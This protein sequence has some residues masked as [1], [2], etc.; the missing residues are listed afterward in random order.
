[1]TFVPCFLW[2]LLGAPYVESLRSNERL[3]GALKAITASVVGV[4]LNL[5]AWLAINVL[6]AAVHESEGPLGTRLLVRDWTTPRVDAA[7][8]ALASGI[9]LVRYHAPLIPTILTAAAVGALV[10]LL[11]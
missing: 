11:V 10:R 8:I 1:M 5:A 6:F 7:A 4:V 2:I 9:G 3:S